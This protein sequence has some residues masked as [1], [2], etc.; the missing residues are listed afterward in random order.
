[1]NR[2]LLLVLAVACVI[3]AAT[4]GVSSRS[5]G[6]TGV[7]SSGCTCHGSTPTSAVVP[8]LSGVPA[9]WEPGVSYDLTVSFTGGPAFSVNPSRM[10]Q[11]GFNLRASGGSLSN[12]LSPTTVAVSGSEATHTSAGNDQTSWNVRWT[13]P[14]GPFGDG[15]ITFTLAVN[16]VNG[17]GANSGDAWNVL[18]RTASGPADTTAPVISEVAAA[19]S[20]TS[21]IITWKTDDDATSIVEYGRTS[22]YTSTA[23]GPSGTLHSVTLSG[24]LSGTEYHYR[25][26]SKNS[27]GLESVSEDH[28]FTTTTDTIPPTITMV[29]PSK[30]LYVANQEITTLGLLGPVS[31]GAFL[32]VDVS[33]TDNVGVTRVD[34]HVDGVY[35]GGFLKESGSTWR[36]RWNT[37]FETTGDHVIHAVARDAVG[38]VRATP[39]LTVTL[40]R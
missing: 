19:P 29:R 25:V 13:A 11:G 40:V 33:A 22:S 18:T 4:A 30:A 2:R 1:M 21:A 31:I 3:I 7:S 6:I 34:F 5:G 14:P 26:R 12:V 37:Q 16:S 10:N 23:T 39:G 28:T 20:S 36:I 15:T 32:V 27:A 35:R 8:T 38:N 24:L 9:T 17:D